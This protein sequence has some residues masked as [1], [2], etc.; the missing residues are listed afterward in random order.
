ML[1]DGVLTEIPVLVKLA[2]TVKSGTTISVKTV[3]DCGPYHVERDFTFRVGRIR[4]SFE[5]S[6]FRVFP[7]INVS[8]K[9]WTIT[10]AGA[11]D[12]NLAARSGSIGHNE[13]TSLMMKTY[14]ETPDSLKFYYYVSSETNYDFLAFY[15]NDTEMFRKSGETYWERKVIPV[16]AGYNKLEWRYKKDQSV[17]QGKDFAMIDMIDFAGPGGVEYIERD[18]V[19]GRIINPVQKDK[20]GREQVA[21]KLMNAGPDTI[22]GFNLAYTI[23]GSIPVRQHFNDVLIPF[24]DSVTVTFDKYADMSRYGFY[25]LITYGYDNDDDY[26][27]NDT[28][29][30]NIEN[31]K[32]NED[33]TVFPNPLD[34]ELSIV[35][36]SEVDATARISLFN[37]SGKILVD[38]EV[39]ILP[40]TNE[41]MI[42]KEDLP[43][44]VYYLRVEYPGWHKVIPVIKARP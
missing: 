27:L 30:V 38:F 6:S 18:I 42:R 2:Q 28:A 35:S 19:T 25:D 3:L 39:V 7:W 14:Y 43:P 12:G 22:R 44:G 15:L 36:N 20:L 17:S 32:I 5:A 33:L 31:T 9:P 24:A 21:V 40:G 11:T 1:Y 37:T 13:T 26:L 41:A 16:P 29:R 4:E 10:D 34:Q 23:N 8:Q